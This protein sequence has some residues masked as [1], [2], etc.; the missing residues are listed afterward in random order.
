M[1]RWIF[2]DLFEYLRSRNNNTFFDSSRYS[3]INYF[4][5]DYVP[6]EIDGD[7]KKLGFNHNNLPININEK[8]IKIDDIPDEVFSSISIP[9]AIE[10]EIDNVVNLIK[11]R[12]PKIPL[13][14][15]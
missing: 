9:L 6:V 8:V 1:F 2:L 13:Q 10:E 4:G 15:I 5:V 3:S 14:F 12:F 11:S 7:V